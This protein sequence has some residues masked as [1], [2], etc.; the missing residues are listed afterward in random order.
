MLLPAG[1]GPSHLAASHAGNQFLKAPCC[2][3][4]AGC[5]GECW[6]CW[7]VTHGCG[8]MMRVVVIL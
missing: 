7:I 6:W 4:I 5:G 1:L 2:A 8:V 3:A